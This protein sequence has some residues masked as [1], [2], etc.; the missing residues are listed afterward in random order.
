MCI[1]TSYRVCNYPI[2]FV[3]VQSFFIL[4]ASALMCASCLS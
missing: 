3:R 2:H 4:L 1:C